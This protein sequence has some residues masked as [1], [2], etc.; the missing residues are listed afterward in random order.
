VN[1]ILGIALEIRL[2][3]LFVLGVCVGSLANLGIYRL[4]WHPR[5]ISPWSRPD[6][7]APLR[8]PGDRVPLLGWLGLRRE[9]A[10]HGAGFWVRPLLV[11]LAVGLGFAALYWWETCRLGLLPPEVPRTLPPQLIAVPHQQYAAHLVLI[12][13][14]IVASLIDIDEKTIPDAITLPGTLLGLAAVAAFPQILLPDVVV[15]NKGPIIF[16]LVHLASPNSWP[17]WLD[18]FPRPWSLVLGLGCWWLWTLAVMPRTWYARHG[19]CRALGLMLAR[20]RREPAT[21][22][23]LAM[24]LAG[25]LCIAAVWLWAD[26]GWVGLVSGLVGVAGGGGLVWLVRIVGRAALGREAMGFGDVTLMSMIG[27]FLGWQACLV[28]FFL[29]PLAGSVVGLL[30]LILRRGREIPFGPFLC[31]ATL[32]LLVCWARLWDW[33]WPIFSL[34]WLLPL[35]LLFIM[36]PLMG[37]MLALWQMARRLLRSLA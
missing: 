27:A 35:I 13:L 29:A 4:C 16:G 15:P 20:L 19:W 10:L 6:A 24:G 28:I 22:L 31:L 33:T 26:A 18:G 37:L 32:V 9:A 34:G 12:S 17:Q 11:E 8:L 30:T 23:V 14:M 7:R 2:A 1:W 36:G 25:S 21:R 3:G 5:P